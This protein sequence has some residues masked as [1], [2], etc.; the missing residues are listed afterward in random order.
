M[1]SSKLTPRQTKPTF[2][3][4]QARPYGWP[5]WASRPATSGHKANPSWA[6]Y[7]STS[8]LYSTPMS[9]LP[10]V[11]NKL[12]KPI[13]NFSLIG[14]LITKF[15]SIEYIYKVWFTLQGMRKLFYHEFF[16]HFLIKRHWLKYWR[17]FL[18]FIAQTTT[19]IVMWLWFEWRIN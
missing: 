9:S 16:S 13:P 10:Q 4:D 12:P 2:L 1:E 18:I 7:F 11:R 6:L 3:A 15:E 17:W 5:H 19:Y 14:N 8:A